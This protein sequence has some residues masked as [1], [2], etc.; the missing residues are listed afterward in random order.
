MKIQFWEDDKWV[1]KKDLVLVLMA[2]SVLGRSVRVL[3]VGC[4]EGGWLLHVGKNAN[5]DEVWG[6]D[7]YPGLAGTR[8]AAIARLSASGIRLN[9]HEDWDSMGESAQF[10]LIHVDGEHSET[11]AYRDLEQSAKWLR[12]GGLIVVDD[13]IQPVFV[14]VN[15]AVHR[16]VAASNFRIVLATEWK[17]YL[18]SEDVADAWKKRFTALLK[19][20]PEVPVLDAS[21]SALGDYVEIPAVH[22]WTPILCL[23]KPTGLLLEKGVAGSGNTGVGRWNTATILRM[24]KRV[25]RRASSSN[26]VVRK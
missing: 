2:L 19:N 1:G 7:P 18:C 6:I 25:V 17:A 3:E 10:S 4:W 22:G 13:W 24:A 23:G 12:P 8:D 9:L 11:A 5:L 14:G 21:Q 16:F 15:S 20:R 26:Q